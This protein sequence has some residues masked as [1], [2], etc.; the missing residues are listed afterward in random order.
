MAS[1]YSIRG[2]LCCLY[3]FCLHTY[4][5]TQVNIVSRSL[6][7]T[8]GNNNLIFIFNIC[9]L[10]REFIILIWPFSHSQCIYVVACTGLFC[11]L[12]EYDPSTLLLNIPLPVYSFSQSSKIP[13]RLLSDELN[14]CM[15]K[16]FFNWAVGQTWK[17]R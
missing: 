6:Q 15:S 14:P 1:S 12:L 7:G 3:I 16:L 13:W 4:E 17:S 2:R 10:F 8:G 5:L 9:I 11:Y